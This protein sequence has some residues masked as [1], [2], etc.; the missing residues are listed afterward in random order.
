[1]AERFGGPHSPGARAPRGS[2]LRTRAPEPM[3][4]RRNLLFLAPLPLVFRAFSGGALDLAGDLLAL[5]ALWGGAWLTSEGVKAEAAFNAQAVARR[6]AIPR[7]LFGLAATGIGVALA[8][9]PD[10][11][12]AGEAEAGAVAGGLL[13]G[14]IAM[15]LHAVAFGMD[16][17]RDRRPEG[18]DAFQHD[19]VA[20]ALDEAER[21]LARMTRAVADLGDRTLT[22]RVAGFH[23]TA[24]AMFA[25][26]A[27]DPRDLTAARRYL[28]VYLQGAADA[29]EKLV[30]IL[31]GGEDRAARAAYMDLLDDLEADYAARTEAL[32]GNDRADL[33]VEIEVLRER[34]SR[35]GLAARRG[36]GME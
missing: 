11:A 20:R 23:D 27:E 3:R 17:L 6:P 1:M 30:Q 26:V 31:R 4:A 19:R 35:E 36:D 25:R 10:G 15:V 14:A 9:L 2:K 24:R 28:G 8:A 18:I 12:L 21:H 33:G 22:R 7:K 16:P 29:T 34:L 5:A 13:L 32:I